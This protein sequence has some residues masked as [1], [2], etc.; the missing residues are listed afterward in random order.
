M[1]S[2][3]S[4]K[5][6]GNSSNIIGNSS[7]ISETGRGNSSK[8]SKKGKSGNSSKTKRRVV[9]HLVHVNYVVNGKSCNTGIYCG[10]T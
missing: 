9:R 6:G 8:A 1:T 2:G 10:K 5:I 4:S 7:Q 3:N